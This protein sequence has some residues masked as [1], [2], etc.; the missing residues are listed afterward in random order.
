MRFAPKSYIHEVIQSG[1]FVLLF[2]NQIYPWGHGGLL[3]EV[4]NTLGL[5]VHSPNDVQEGDM[6][7]LVKW[8]DHQ[9]RRAH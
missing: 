5:K 1:G 6:Q 3:A 4:R 9:V 8:H 7:R 2:E